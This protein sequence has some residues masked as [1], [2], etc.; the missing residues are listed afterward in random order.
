MNLPNLLDQHLGD[1]CDQCDRAYLWCECA[2][3]AYLGPEA[4]K[5]AETL[6]LACE[7][8]ILEDP[9]ACPPGNGTVM[10]IW[11]AYRRSELR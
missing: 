11:G 3:P 10:R 9:A 2:L 6:G 8:W 7:R 5:D 1:R 4:F